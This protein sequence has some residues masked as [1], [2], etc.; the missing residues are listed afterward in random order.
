MLN[1]SLDL[2]LEPP[3]MPGEESRRLNEQGGGEGEKGREARGELELDREEWILWSLG[4]IERP[5]LNK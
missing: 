4:V 1:R 5:T 2:S 3:C